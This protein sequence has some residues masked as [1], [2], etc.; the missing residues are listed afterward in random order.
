MKKIILSTTIICLVFGMAFFSLSSKDKPDYKFVFENDDILSFHITVNREDWLKMWDRPFKYVKCTIKFGDEVYQDVGL[1]FKGNSS[2]S[3]GGLKKSY[4]FK[5]DEF[6]KKQCF[7]GFKKL[8]FSNGFKD[9]SLLRE[10]L[11]YDLFKVAG[12]PASRATFAKLY[13][14]IPGEYDEE[15][16]GFYTLVEQVDKVFLE[17]RFGDIEGC[18]FKGEGMSD[19]IYRGDD[20]KRYERDYEAK[21]SKKQRDYSVLIRFIKM[22]N[23]TPEE[24][25]PFEIENTFNVETFLSWLAVNTLLSNL[26][27]YAGTGHNYY[28]YFNKGTG[29]FEFIPWDLN[30]AFGNFQMGSAQEMMELDIYE[31]YAKPK[32]LIER[33]L[34]VPKFKERYI[35]KIKTLMD[36]SFQQSAMYSKINV[37]Y[38]KIEKGVRLDM[39]KD[40]TTENFE[41]SVEQ[42][43][44]SQRHPRVDIVIGLKPFVSE[45][46]K[47]VKAQLAGR[48][49][50]FVPRSFKPPR[51]EDFAPPKAFIELARQLK[52]AEELIGADTKQAIWVIEH[53]TDALKN[54]SKRLG[55]PKGEEMDK[56][57]RQLY[58]IREEIAAGGF[59]A[60]RSDEIKKFLKQTRQMVEKAVPSPMS[61][62]LNRKLDELHRLMEE[63]MDEGIDI[64]EAKKLDDKSKEYAQRGDMK[65]AINLIS[66]AIDLLKQQ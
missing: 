30:E 42:H 58:S 15:Y 59:S 57:S 62:E 19:L 29:K 28:L 39:W 34:R 21:L 50:G 18:L 51:G 41:N 61:D 46:I 35:E 45:R 2:S 31:P 12:V 17:D 22:L 54:L 5:F 37:L 32:L 11:A 27:S 44:Q 3:V 24:R 13:L 8:N 25:F 16:I 7:H 60:R 48:K 53:A 55:G 36:D 65:G 14:T 4:K 64:T 52:K 1:R 47:S 20:P 56:A 10:K 9:P 40:F 63:K 43:I 49:R 23:E 38:K 66:K 6:D 26:D 33:I